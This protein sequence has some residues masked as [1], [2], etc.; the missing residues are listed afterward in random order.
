MAELTER[1]SMGWVPDYPDFRD[2]DINKD[3]IPPSKL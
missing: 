1:M 2:Y 3:D